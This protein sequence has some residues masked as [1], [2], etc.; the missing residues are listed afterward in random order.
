MTSQI[1]TLAYEHTNTQNPGSRLISLDGIPLFFRDLKM[2]QDPREE[3]ME[4]Q[5]YLPS[6][7][8]LSHTLKR[9]GKLMEVPG[10]FLKKFQAL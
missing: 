7:K 8:E 1:K 3:M 10:G 4:V 9:A 6:A 5:E 2:P